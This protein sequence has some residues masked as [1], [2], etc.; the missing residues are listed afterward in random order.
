MNMPQLH[1]DL[2]EARFNRNHIAYYARLGWRLWPPAQVARKAAPSP[3]ANT[4][5]LSGNFAGT[6]DTYAA[7]VAHG[8]S[9]G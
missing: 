7:A 2:D 3:D 1:G 9:D 5:G 8:G 6:C 4:N